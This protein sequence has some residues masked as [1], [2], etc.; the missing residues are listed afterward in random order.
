[1]NQ[2][3]GTFK[4]YFYGF[5]ISLILTIMAYLLVSKH[6]L[7]GKLLILTVVSLG[8]LQAVAQLFYFL[9]LGKEGHPRWGGLIFCFMV[10]VLLIIVLGSLWIMYSLDARMM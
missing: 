5:I 9:H 2:W 4:S 8:C 1:M 3:T 7:S 6:L 10:L